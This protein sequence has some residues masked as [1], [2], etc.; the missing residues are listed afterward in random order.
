MRHADDEGLSSLARQR[1][2]APVDD[3]SGNENSDR[4]VLGLEEGLD[5]ENGSL[6][7]G[8]VEDRLDQKD[9]DAAVEKAPNLLRVRRNNFVKSLKNNNN[10]T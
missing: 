3:C 2:T 8:R 5:G 4:L 1:S 7:V 10:K 6:A 9:V